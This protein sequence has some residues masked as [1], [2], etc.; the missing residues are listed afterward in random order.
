MEFWSKGLGTRKLVLSLGKS[1]FEVKEG[2]VILTGT[3]DAPADWNYRVQ[4]EKNDLISILDMATSAQLAT[5][6]AGCRGKAPLRQ[7]LLGTLKVIVRLGAY[8]I[9]IN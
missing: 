7:L 1:S 8:S 3:V 4:L 2:K 9:F 5:Y 6:L